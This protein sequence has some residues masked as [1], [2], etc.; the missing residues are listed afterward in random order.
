MANGS[1]LSSIINPAQVNVLGALDQ[2]R[3]RQATDLAGDILGQ[4][5]GGKIGELAQLSPDK[6]LRLAE[7]TGIP[8]NSQGRIKNL[9]GINVIGAKLL[10]AGQLQE[11]AQFLEEEAT[12]VESL[13]GEPATRLR[14]VQQAILT[15]DQETMNNFIQ[16][17]LSLDPTNAQTAQQREFSGLTEGLSAEDELKARRVKLRIDAP[18]TGSAAQTIAALGTAEDV[19]ASEAII[20]ERKKFAELTGASRA[21]FIDKGFDN[22]VKIDKNIR[23]LGRAITALDDGASTGVI[24]SRFFPSFRKAT[25]QL[26]ALQKELSLDVIGAVTFGALSQGELDLAMEVALPTNLEPADLR[27][28]LVDKKDAQEKLRG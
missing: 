8:V 15:G 5:I 22:I 7:A 6:A 12:K 20:A 17:G 16:A 1:L 27:Q 2:G 19:G 11:A 13:T 21:K 24:E 4:T 26:E 23:N 3:E 18:A 28:H 14:A 9:V 25:L 10:Q